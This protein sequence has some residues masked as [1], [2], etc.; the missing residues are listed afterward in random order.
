MR[1]ILFI[2]IFCGLPSNGFACLVA[3][4]QQI[5]SADELIDRTQRI[6]LAKAISSKL[7]PETNRR[8]KDDT[9]EYEFEVVEVIKGTIDKSFKIP[10]GSRI[11][12]PK[13]FNSF[14]KIPTVSSSPVLPGQLTEPG[15]GQEL[16][17]NSEAGRVMNSPDCAIYPSFNVGYQYLIFLDKPY[18]RKSFELIGSEDKWLAY[19][20]EKVNGTR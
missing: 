3:P 8:D 7:S 19:V 18:H 16:F 17:W 10:F 5:V 6:V 13:D 20:K 4:L 12:S 11:Q 14:T 15:H 2:L 1:T 9:I